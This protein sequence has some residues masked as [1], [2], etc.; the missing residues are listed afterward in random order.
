MAAGPSFEIVC[1]T[2]VSRFPFDFLM[3]L[4]A[5]SLPMALTSCR[6]SDEPATDHSLEERI[7]SMLDRYPDATVAV[8][9]IDSSTGTRVMIEA[10]RVFH[11]ASTM[12]VPVMIEVFRQVEL[13]RLSLDD[14]IIVENRFRSI[15]DGS[16]FTI[17]DDSDD[18]LYERSGQPVSVRELLHKMIVVSSNL[19][20]NLLIDRVS[21][22]TVQTTIEKLGTRTMH[23]YRGVEDLK[24]F[25]R[26]LNN[27]ATAADLALLMEAIRHGRA[28]SPEACRQMVDILLDQEFNDMIPAGLPADVSVAHKT[29][30]ITGIAHDAAIVYPPDAEPYTLVILTEGFEDHATAHSFGAEIARTI[31]ASI[32]PP[33]ENL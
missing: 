5:M 17:E 18:A 14:E 27:T 11:A 24:A 13:G 19:A 7:R 1:I 30:S 4:L 31:H 16:I 33:A 10:D 32:R 9:L 23:V 26:G 21:A 20:T 8:A 6:T 12:K 3:L 29:G 2:G 22:D 25:D 15:V 28:V